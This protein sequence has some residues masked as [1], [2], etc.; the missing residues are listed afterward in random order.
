LVWE[1]IE[2]WLGD[3]LGVHAQVTHRWV[4]TVGYTDDGLPYAGAV[5]DQ[6]GLYVLG[7][8]SGHGNVPGYLAGKEVA[9]LVAGDPGEPVLSAAS[10]RE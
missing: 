8:Y 7:G 4:G 1:R 3:S 10:A 2:G 6:P 5:P 9:D